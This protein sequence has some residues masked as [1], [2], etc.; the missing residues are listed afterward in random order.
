MKVHRGHPTKQGSKLLRWA[1]VEA[2]QRAPEGTPMR[3][4]RDRIEA[5]RG[6]E[7]QS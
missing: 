7:A 2:V 1:A 4:H 3:L 5:R 6:T